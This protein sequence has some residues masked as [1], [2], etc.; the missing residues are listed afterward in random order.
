MLVGAVVAF[1]VAAKT[2][3]PWLGVVAGTLRRRGD[4]AHLRRDR[5]LAD[6]EPGGDRPRALALRRRPLRVRRPRL[7]CRAV[8]EG[9]T[10]LAI[11]GLSDIPVIGPLLFGHNPLVYLSIAALRRR[12]VVPLPHPRRASCCARSA[13][14]RT[15]AHAIGYPVI[16][17][18]YARG[19]V[20]RRVLRTR[21]RLPVGR[22]HAA[23]GRGHDRG[24]R[25]DRARAG[26]VRD[27]EAVARA[28]RRLPVRRRDARVSSRRRRWARRS[29]RSTCRCCPTSRPSSCSRSSRATRSR[30]G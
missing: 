4:L 18:R 8:I 14:R 30:S 28:G 15:S 11:P 5:A 16:R 24:P 20:R 19:R 26:R 13:S 2:G 7:T 22:L 9:I 3:S 27:L 12:A 10:P 29:P 1:M 21:R 25:L 6:G 17:I 23:V